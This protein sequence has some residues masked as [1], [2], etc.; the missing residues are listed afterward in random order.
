[1]NAFLV[2]IGILIVGL[3]IALWAVKKFN[4]TTKVFGIPLQ[5]VLDIALVLVAIIAVIVIKT[6]LGGKNKTIEALLT[7]LNIMKAQNNI[8]IVN[9]H[10]Q[11][12]TDAIATIDQKIKELQPATQQKDIDNLLAQQAAI[13][14]QMQ[15]LNQQKQNHTES[16][17]TLE[18]KIKDMEAL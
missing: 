16:Q 17:K 2:I 4:V 8:N 7:K 14:Q 12:K 9:D 11:D 1:M 13:K 15:D 10:I 18:Q 5:Y 6:A 3:L